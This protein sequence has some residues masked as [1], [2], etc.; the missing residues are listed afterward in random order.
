MRIA[1][2]TAGAGGFYCGACSHDVTLARA[3]LA[4]GIDVRLIPLY[5]PLKLD[6][7][8]PPGTTRT[9]F[10]GVSVYLEQYVPPFRHVPRLLNR[11]LAARPVLKLASRFGIRT[12][13]EDLGPLTVSVLKGEHGRQAMELTEL[14]DFLAAGPLPDVVTITNSF[15]SGIAPALK[16]RLGLPVVCAVQ[17]EDSF[18]DAIPAP[19]GPRARDLMRSNARSIDLFVSPSEAYAARMAKFLDVPRDR[20]RVV[21][22]GIDTACFPPARARPRIPF[23]VGY[24]S[25]IARD[26]GLDTLIEALRILVNEWKRDAHLCVAGQVAEHSFWTSV[27]AAVRRAGL[28]A[29]FRYCEAPDLAGKLA[30]LHGCSVFAYPGRTPEPDAVAVMEAMATGLP[31]VVP[32]AGIFPEMIGLTAGVLVAPNE[33]AD[34]ADALAALMDDPDLADRLGAAGQAAIR[35]YY[36]SDAMA[37]EMASVYSALKKG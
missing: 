35:K 19:H 3:L 22:T 2:I 8:E 20:I 33:P 23:T 36:S 15:L 14:L 7:P 16:T 5:T 28:S 26:K 1:Y 24:L 21:R 12:K 30:F 32:R 34:L 37:E 18:V 31:V 25:R 10:G 29:R 27:R 17:G 11:I 4:R 6:R 13:P 9:F